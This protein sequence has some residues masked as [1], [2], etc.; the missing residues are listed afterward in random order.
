MLQSI[1]IMVATIGVAVGFMAVV[2]G[3]FR[4]RAARQEQQRDADTRNSRQ[5]GGG[6]ATGTRG[7]SSLNDGRG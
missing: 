7:R 3:V 2:T 5:L 4:V 6:G 1:L